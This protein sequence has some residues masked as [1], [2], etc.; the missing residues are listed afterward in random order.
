MVGK[1]ED[2]VKPNPFDAIK[3]VLEERA[4]A[5]ADE[6]FVHMPEPIGDSVYILECEGY[7]KI[8]TSTRPYQRLSSIQT[9][10]PFKV[11]MRGLMHGGMDTEQ[12]L[13]SELA[14]HHHQGEW[15]HLNEES[16]EIVRNFFN[17]R[18]PHKVIFGLEF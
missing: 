6:W 11:H 10:C 3:E 4:E 18:D 13:H 17:T 14:R 15:Y 8:G 16:I 1:N 9:G 5:D 12:L 7:I 2:Y